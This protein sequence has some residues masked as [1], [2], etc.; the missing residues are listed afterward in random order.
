[1]VNRG[2][3]AKTNQEKEAG[4]SKVEVVVEEEAMEVA[5][6]RFLGFSL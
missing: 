3:M 5:K 4:D 1:M 2:V 6:V